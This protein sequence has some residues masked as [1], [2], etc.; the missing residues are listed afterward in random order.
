MPRKRSVRLGH[1][2]RGEVGILHVYRDEFTKAVLACYADPTRAILWERVPVMD[3][4]NTAA[5][6][7]GIDR[8]SEG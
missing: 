2:R 5:N 8:P 7:G 4:P 3:W 6:D 1:G